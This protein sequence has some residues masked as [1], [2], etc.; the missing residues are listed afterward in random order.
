MDACRQ[1]WGQ[2]PVKQSCLTM[3]ILPV[4]LSGTLEGRRTSWSITR[5]HSQ[6]WP[7]PDLPDHG[8]GDNNIRTSLCAHARA[9]VCVCVR[10]F[11][12][13]GVLFDL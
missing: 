13:V 7:E 10:A 11:V 12:C 1:R 3:P 4:Y 2:G 6:A 5:A 8:L 9:C